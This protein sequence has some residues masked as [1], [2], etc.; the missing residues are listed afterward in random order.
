MAADKK[1]ITARVVEEL[2]RL[3]A[4][5]GGWEVRG[6]PSMVARRV[7]LHVS[8]VHKLLK[9]GA[10]YGGVSMSTIQAVARASGKPVEW[11]ISGEEPRHTSNGHEPKASLPPYETTQGS[12]QT[13]EELGVTDERDKEI[14]REQ[15]RRYPRL[16]SNPEALQAYLMGVRR[17]RRDAL[18]LADYV[19]VERRRV[20]LQKPKP[21]PDSEG[22]PAPPRG[23]GKA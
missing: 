14:L 17:G 7:G 3:H 19:R 5:E 16:M 18:D 4:A 13:L 10:D 22:P 15:L 11:F 6:A 20:Q 9:S 23:R 1:Q 8:L 2:S 12:D 21:N